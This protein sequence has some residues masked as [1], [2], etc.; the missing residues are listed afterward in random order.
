MLYLQF[1]LSHRNFILLCV[2]FKLANIFFKW[3]LILL[4]INDLTFLGLIEKLGFTT[5]LVHILWSSQYHY[6]MDARNPSH[7]KCNPS[8]L[9]SMLKSLNGKRAV[10][11]PNQPITFPSKT[12]TRN[13]EIATAF[14][15]QFISTP[16]FSPDIVAQVIRNSGNSNSAGPDGLTI[17]H[18]KNQGLLWF[19][20]LTHLYNLLVNY[21]NIPVI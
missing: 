20:Y 13:L 4:K 15:K 19:Q 1:I 7:L 18:H 21:C 12:L 14:A 2:K 11:P 10:T 6:N 5:C 9:W 8:G 3:Q 17:H 16:S